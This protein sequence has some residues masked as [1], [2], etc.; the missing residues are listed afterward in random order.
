MAIP[1]VGA[2]VTTA[3]T[4]SGGSSSPLTGSHTTDASTNLLIVAVHYGSN[5][6][7]H[8]IAASFDGNAMIELITIANEDDSRSDIWYLLA[9][10]IKTAT[11][12]VG[13]WGGGEV[14]R[15]SW[16][17]INII[18]ANQSIPFGTPATDIG[19]ISTQITVSAASAVGELVIAT[20]LAKQ[21]PVT[22]T[23]GM[24]ITEHSNDSHID[25]NGGTFATGTKIG[26]TLTAMDW[27]ISTTRFWSEIAVG[28]KPLTTVPVT[29]L[30][31]KSHIIDPA[32]QRASLF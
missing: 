1:T 18:G 20:C 26:A 32:T 10:D 2:T 5:A 14:A 13:P 27:A 9:P 3:K 15:A 23:S 11:I 29:N 19:S 22:L 4:G 8:A 21:G 16:T 6:D 17:A 24:G 31:P 12:S 25:A 30:P 28:I 7:R